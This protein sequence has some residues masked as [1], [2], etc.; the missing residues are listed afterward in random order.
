MTVSNTTS[1][2]PSIPTEIIDP[3]TMSYLRN[4]I[5]VCNLVRQKD[6]SG[7]PG[8]KCDF[9]SYGSLSAA[10]KTQ[11]TDFTPAEL[12]TS[13]D[14]T[15]TAAEVGV[16]IQIP[17][18]VQ[19]AAP[20]LTDDD[21]AR[22][23]ANA[24]AAKMETD[25]A[26]QFADFTTEKG[27]TGTQMSMST[28]EDAL[29]ALR[30]AKAPTEAPP[31]SNIPAGLTGYNCV[32]AE[33]GVAQLMRSIRQGGL[34]VQSPSITNMLESFGLKG[35]GAIRFS[36]LGVNVWAQDLVVTSGS[37]RSG[38]MFT[39]GAIGL[40]MKRKPRIEDQRWAIGTQKYRAGSTV[41]G[42]NGIKIVL[43]VEIVHADAMT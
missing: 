42:T 9:N 40:V 39:P 11:G 21:M 38:A 19:E 33:S 36:F 24:V 5:V 27:G 31:D 18:I 26:A 6:I 35:A 37:D 20:G 41:Y 28:F 34:A 25:V 43:G 17:D 15:V 30:Q 14:G 32:L 23:L 13:E 3:L 2:G 29:L 8:L 16:A 22:E 12:T 4:A 1:F 7:I 10:A